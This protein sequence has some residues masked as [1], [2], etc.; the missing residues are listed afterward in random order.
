[1]NK[2]ILAKFTERE[3]EIVVSVLKDLVL[4]SYVDGCNAHDL[5]KL[6]QGLRRGG[7]LA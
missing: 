7:A 3:A 5:D 1:M 6:A 4:D 2:A